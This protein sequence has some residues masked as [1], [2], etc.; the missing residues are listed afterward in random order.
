MLKRPISPH[1]QIYNVF[2][3]ELTSAMSITHRFAEIG[4]FVSLLYSLGLF[5]ALAFGEH[6]YNTYLSFIFSWFGWVSIFAI[7]VCFW[8]YIFGAIRFTI[9]NLG[10]GINK[11]FV[12]YS[13]YIT[14]GLFLTGLAT[15]WYIIL[16]T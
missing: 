14:L 16:F 3:K 9:F 6:A 5:V 1:L 7:S 11:K 12:M 15:T 2:A 8:F 4:L 13:G 10:Y